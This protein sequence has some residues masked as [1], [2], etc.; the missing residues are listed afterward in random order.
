MKLTNKELRQI[1]K[2][3]LEYVL[4]EEQMYRGNIEVIQ[5]DMD[6][7]AYQ[8]EGASGNFGGRQSLSISIGM[9]YNERTQENAE[10]IA[11][12]WVSFLNRQHGL[13]LDQQTFADSI[14]KGTIRLYHR[15][16]QRNTGG[17]AGFSSSMGSFYEE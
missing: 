1:I 2:E 16:K 5:G 15:T 10:N 11:R 17:G 14:R 7:T 4:Q 6:T 13:S 8:V 12:Q 9:Y 3:E